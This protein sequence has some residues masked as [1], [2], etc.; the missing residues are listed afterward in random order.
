MD[1]TK[2]KPLV[3][4][5]FKRATGLEMAAECRDA[6]L[7]KVS[8]QIDH[9]TRLRTSHFPLEQEVEQQ[10][11]FFHSSRGL[12]DSSWIR[13]KVTK[14][15]V[16]LAFQSPRRQETSTYAKGTQIMYWVN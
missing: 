5:T 6:I 3:F 8:V 13:Q 2:V 16:P 7:L 15:Y 11:H 10:Q 12:L 9:R 4:R 14:E 1:G